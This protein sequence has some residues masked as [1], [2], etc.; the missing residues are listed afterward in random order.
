MPSIVM[1][2][3]PPRLSPIPTKTAPARS[4]IVRSLEPTFG[5][6]SPQALEPA[7]SRCW[8]KRDWPCCSLAWFFWATAS[9]IKWVEDM[10]YSFVAEVNSAGNSKVHALSLIQRFVTNCSEKRRAGDCVC[11]QKRHLDR[12]SDTTVVT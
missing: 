3:R 1:P 5:Q 12:R 6:V 10:T 7:F 2:L 9:L 4:D 11:H 8:G